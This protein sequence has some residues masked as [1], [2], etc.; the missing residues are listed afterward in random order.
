MSI[1]SDEL[2]A[3][4]ICKTSPPRRLYLYLQ[5]QRAP[6]CIR[7]LPVGISCISACFL[8]HAMTASRRCASNR[9]AAGRT[10]PVLL[11]S[12][13]PRLPILLRCTHTTCPPAACAHARTPRLFLALYL[14]PLLPLHPTHT[15][16][17]PHI[18]T[19]FTPYYCCLHIC[20]QI[21]MSKKRRRTLLP[22]CSIPTCHLF[23]FFTTCS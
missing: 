9:R 2:D 7:L 3:V 15:L 13:A 17:L 12:I 16:A 8:L 22:C 21:F 19:P 1:F 4:S 14:P 20:M 23:S 18:S 10:P 5:R 6:L 11:I